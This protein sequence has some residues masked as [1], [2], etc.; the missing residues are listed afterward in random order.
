MPSVAI[1]ISKIL[2][3]SRQPYDGGRRHELAGTLYCKA[4]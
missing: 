2:N 3:K 1:S 4:N